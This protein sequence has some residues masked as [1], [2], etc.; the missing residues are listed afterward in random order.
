MDTVYRNFWQCWVDSAGV[1]GQM[2]A[3]PWP[4]SV[5][6]IDCTQQ[7][8]NQMV[9]V[10]DVNVLWI[11][12]QNDPHYNN[13]PVQMARGTS[14]NSP[15]WTCPS[16][17]SSPT[18]LASNNFKYQGQCCWYDQQNGFDTY[19]NLQNPDGTPATYQNDSIYIKPDCSRHD[20][21][22]E[23]GG[24]PFGVTAGIPVLVK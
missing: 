17:C 6:V 10:V 23:T 16:Y 7:T 15:V 19:F 22:G 11:T 12:D 14:S 24:G 1:N 13:V 5:P 9:G 3:V 20:P 21:K 2:P 18:Y 8:C 4:L